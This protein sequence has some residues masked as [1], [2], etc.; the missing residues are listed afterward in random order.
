LA[1]VPKLLSHVY[2]PPPVAETEIDVVPQVNSVVPVLLVILAVG[3]VV[4]EVKV[5]LASSVHPLLAVTVTVYVPA[6]VGLVLAVFVLLLQAY[7]PPPV[8]VSDIL[9]CEQVI[10][11]TPSLFVIPAVGSVISCV[12]VILSVS[13]HPLD[14]VVLTLYVP[15]DVMV[16]LADVPNELFQ[17]YVDPPLAVK[18]I[19]VVPHVNSEVPVLLVITAVGA[20]VLELTV[21]FSVSV[22]PL[23]PVTVTVYVPADVIVA[24]AD[25]PNDPLHEYELPPVAVTLIEV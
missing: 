15:G 4:L 18:L 7:V 24:F 14:A 20:V 21:I 13:V 23:D 8:A 6:V 17:T 1:D 10:S 19:D 22:H 11:V 9:V 3:S 5:T 25:V 12:I 2:V 16:T